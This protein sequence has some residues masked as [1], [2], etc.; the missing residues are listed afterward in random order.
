MVRVRRDDDIE[1]LIVLLRTVYLAEGYPANWPSDPNRWLRGTF[2]VAAWVCEERG[3][4]VGHLALTKPD[5]DRAWPQ[6][7]QALQVPL[8]RLAVMRRLFVAPNSRRK[9]VGTELV[10]IAERTAADRGLPL[11]LDVADHNRAAIS[12]WKR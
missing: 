3:E 9:G 12:F 10:K 1:P 4:L 7:A 11:A 2:T 8:E 5:P 6:W